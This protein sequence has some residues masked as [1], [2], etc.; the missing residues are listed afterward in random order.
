MGVIEVEMVLALGEGPLMWKR[1][2]RS[3]H[4]NVLKR[5][6]VSHQNRVLL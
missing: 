3:F 4:E 5:V 6:L 1:E 2:G